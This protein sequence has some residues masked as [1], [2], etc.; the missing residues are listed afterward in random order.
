MGYET[1]AMS[2]GY[3]MKPMK[4]NSYYRGGS[5]T[6]GDDSSPYKTPQGFKNS[7]SYTNGGT[8]TNNPAN[9]NS[10]GANDSPLRGPAGLT[11]GGYGAT[12]GGPDVTES[13][14]Q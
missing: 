8:T 9:F 5:P 4:R 3:A 6:P 13:M 12:P 2:N 10:G 7:G 1:T 14:V 11:A